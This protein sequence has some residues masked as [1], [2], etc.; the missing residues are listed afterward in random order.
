[1]KK[2]YF[3]V[4]N[5]FVLTIFLFLTNCTQKKEFYPL[6]PSVKNEL[7]S[8]DV[9]FEKEQNK[10]CNTISE[11]RMSQYTGSM[12]MA[13]V[14]IIV[15]SRQENI[16]KELS[17]DMEVI[18]NHSSLNKKFREN[19][20]EILRSCD[21]I[22]VKNVF[23]HTE[24]SMENGKNLSGNSD[25][26]I[27]VKFVYGT[28]E[29]FDNIYGTLYL[30]MTPESDHLKKAL[31]Y[32]KDNSPPIFKFNVKTKYALP[33][34]T[35]DKKKNVNIWISNKGILIKRAMDFILKDIQEKTRDILRNPEILPDN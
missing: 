31:D 2:K 19:I 9:F 29:N 32:N 16:A 35:D 27:N 25:A 3:N 17:Q 30:D 8:C 10:L 23:H 6:S 18:C 15:M 20:E 28:S 26:L 12:L 34:P 7:K 11:S 22:E 21:W 24:S 5:L 13:V 14:D 33:Q 1:M 4:Y